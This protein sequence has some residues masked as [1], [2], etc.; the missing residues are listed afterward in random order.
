MENLES[1]STDFERAQ[2]DTQANFSIEA[3]N[4]R[5]RQ[6]QLKEGLEQ[7]SNKVRPGFAQLEKEI[8]GLNF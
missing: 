3:T 6:A 7:I 4:L 5:T 1:S 8:N 2:F